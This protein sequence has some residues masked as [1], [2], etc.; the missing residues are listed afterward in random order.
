MEALKHEGEE[1]GPTG[2]TQIARECPQIIKEGLAAHQRAAQG[3]VLSVEQVEQCVK[4]KRQEIEGGEERCEVL[5][6]M[7]K[8]VFQM[9]A[10]SFEGIVVFILDFPAG[11][12]R[13]HDRRN[14]FRGERRLG[15]KGIV[16]Q[17]SPR[18]IRERE[19]TP[20]DIQG[21]CACA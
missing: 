2:K 21:I 1:M 15:H 16:V 12:A 14:G 19:F 20:I 9:I 3:A 10:L 18:G 6:P 8:V 7:P 13:L 11:A 17:L 4:K 5:R